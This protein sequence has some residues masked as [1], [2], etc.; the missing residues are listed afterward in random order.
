MTT[1]ADSTYR[2]IDLSLALREAV[3]RLETEFAGT[4]GRETVETFVASSF[5]HLAEGARVMTYVS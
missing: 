1:G 4:Y 3:D 2:S 5:D